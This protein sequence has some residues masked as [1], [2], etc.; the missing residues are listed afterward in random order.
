MNID[1]LEFQAYI[2]RL[3][4][5]LD[6]LEE[7]IDS[8]Q[9]KKNCIEGEELLDNQDILFE[10]NISDRSLQRLRASHKLLYYLI[11]GKANYKLSDVNRY[12]RDLLREKAGCK[13]RQRQISPKK[14]RKGQKRPESQKRPKE[15]KTK[16]IVGFTENYK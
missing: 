7:K 6:I 8:L 5:R 15:N 3:F 10:F 1:K 16:Q 9:R 12:L 4:D 11:H 13:A 14:A 2:D